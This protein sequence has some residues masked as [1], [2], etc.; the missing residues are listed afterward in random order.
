[1]PEPLEDM[2]IEVRNG[3]GNMLAAY[4]SM[5]TDPK[6][7][8]SLLLDLPVAKAQNSCSALSNERLILAK[9]ADRVPRRSDKFH[10]VFFR[11]ESRHVQMINTVI[12]DQAHNSSM[13]VFGS[14]AGLRK[15]LE[16]YL[17][18]P[19]LAKGQHSMKTVTDRKDDPRLLSLRKLEHVAHTIGSSVKARYHVD[20]LMDYDGA[21]SFDEAMV[22]VLKT[23][24]PVL[25]NNP[26]E[27]LMVV[28]VEVLQ[29]LQMNISTI[30]TLDY[31]SST[32]AL[33][34]RSAYSI[35]SVVRTLRISTSTRRLL[36]ISAYTFGEPLGT[37]CCGKHWS[38][39]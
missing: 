4:A 28:L 33:P 9:G 3:K 24:K 26:S 13:L 36:L 32:A 5:H 6:G 2:N 34:I 11:L 23:A 30:H 1:M 39:H 15:A 12:L 10:F 25:S 7:A 21:V 29:I 14:K 37:H 31:L 35:L 17:D 18:Y 22:S 27:T 16:F 20:P 19:I 8:T 38:L